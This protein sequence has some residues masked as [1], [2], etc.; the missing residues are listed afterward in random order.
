MVPL[1]TT[2]SKFQYVSHVL[3]AMYGGN[4]KPAMKHQRREVLAFTNDGAGLLKDYLASYTS[5]SIKRET[6]S[7]VKRFRETHTCTPDQRKYIF[8]WHRVKQTLYSIPQELQTCLCCFVCPRSERPEPTPSTQ[9]GKSHLQPN[10]WP[11]HHL[12]Q[13]RALINRSF[14]QYLRKV[15]PHFSRHGFLPAGDP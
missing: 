9:L 8:V 4:G 5:L 3:S 2:I 15:V 11:L 6:G 14:F 10:I 12:Q 1:P 7:S 13:M